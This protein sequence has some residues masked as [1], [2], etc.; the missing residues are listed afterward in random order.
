MTSTSR[1]SPIQPGTHPELASLEEKI[2]RKRGKITPLY[3][4]LLNSPHMADGWEEFLSVVRQRNSLPPNLRELIILRVAVLNHAPYEFEAHISHARQAGLSDDK[5]QA[6]REPVI[7]SLF[8]QHER[9]ILQLADTMT[10]QIQVPDELFEKIAQHY[11]GKELL[12]L[13][14]TIGAY[15]MVSRVL[16]ALNIGH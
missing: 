6:V 2:I 7:S 13:C 5:I 15:N 12:D 10:Q 3:Q 4:Y 14:I 16:V 1:L 8:T 11:A 9:L